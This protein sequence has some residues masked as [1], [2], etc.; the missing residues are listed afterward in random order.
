MVTSLTPAAGTSGATVT[1][2]GAGFLY[3]SSVNFGSTPA[4]S[5]A[6]VS[7][8]ELRATAPGGSGAVDV[9]VTTGAGTSATSS[10]DQFTYTNSG[11]LL[12][13]SDGGI[14]NYGDAASTVPREARH[15]TLRLSAWRTTRRPAATGRWPP[16]AGVF[17]FNDA[18]FYGSMGGRHAQRAH[19]RHGG[20]GRRCRLL[21]GRQGRRASLPTVTPSSTARR[22]GQPLNAPVVGHRGRQRRRGGYWEVASDGGHLQLRRPLPAARGGQPLNA[23]IVGHGGHGRRRAATGW[24]PRTGASSTTAPPA[25]TARGAASALN[26]PVVGMAAD[27]ATGRL[28][29]GGLRRRHLRLRR[30]L[31]GF[32]RRSATER[33]DRRGGR[34]LTGAHSHLACSPRSAREHPAVP[35]DSAACQTQAVARY[36][37]PE[38]VQSFDAALGALDLSDAVA[39]AGAGSLAAADGRFSVVQVVTG[40]PDDVQAGGGEVNL[41]LTVAEGK[42]RL[43]LD[44]AGTVGGTATIVLGYAEAL[45]MARRRARPG[46]CPGGGARAGAGR[47]GGAGGRPG[48]AGRRGGAPGHRPRRADGP[49]GTG[50][51]RRHHGVPRFVRGVPSPA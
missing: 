14:F 9:T 39:A 46:R 48:R 29:G 7:P 3:G 19:R 17:G 32:A 8:Y 51:L 40:V 22:G 45:A 23:P 16:T 36:L 2:N 35:P 31:P 24:S 15:S 50:A 43:G 49:A 37:T 10:A 12:V 25:S 28:L 30:P 18:S 47:P 11:Y 4:T 42:A 13:A 27:A 38:W 1:I 41:V 34:R 6:Y 5:V 44:P 20:H 21:A 33:A 26:A